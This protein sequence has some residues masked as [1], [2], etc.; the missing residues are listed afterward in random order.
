MRILQMLFC[1]L[2]CLAVVA[3][4]LVAAFLRD[5]LAVACCLLGAVVFGAAMFLA[6]GRADANEPQTPR[7]DFMHPDAP[8][9]HAEDDPDDDKK[10]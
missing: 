6:R 8:D 10:G 9:E 4:A 1:I 7:R 5:L 3:A 2:A